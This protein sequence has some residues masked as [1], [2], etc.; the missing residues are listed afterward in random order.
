MAL[1]NLIA[2]AAMA[3]CALGLLGLSAYGARDD[4]YFY[5]SGNHNL[6]TPHITAA[7][8]AAG[9]LFGYVAWTLT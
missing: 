7:L 6:A 4:L 3:I 9:L 1:L 5:R 8:A 2:A